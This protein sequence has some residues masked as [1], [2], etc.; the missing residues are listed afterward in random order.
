MKEIPS[1]HLFLD[2]F[3]NSVIFYSGQSQPC[4]IYVNKHMKSNGRE[5]I[6]K[7][8]IAELGISNIQ[9]KPQWHTNL[10]LFGSL[11]FPSFHD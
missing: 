7:H 5:W 4:S 8:I 11:K 1:S 10:R 9:K 3:R 2:S 6:T